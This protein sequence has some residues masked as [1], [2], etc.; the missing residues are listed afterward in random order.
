[1]PVK[2]NFPWKNNKNN[3]LRNIYFKEDWIVLNV[4]PSYISSKTKYNKQSFN[5]LENKTKKLKKNNET[6]YFTKSNNKKKSSNK[7]SGYTNVYIFFMNMEAYILKNLNFSLTF[8][9]TSLK[10]FSFY[11][12]HKI[13]K[14]F[15]TFQFYRVSK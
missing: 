11:K 6:S 13:S 2:T 1:M 9:I 12:H 15:L 10:Q 14:H 8:F 7:I 3:V 4:L 5:F